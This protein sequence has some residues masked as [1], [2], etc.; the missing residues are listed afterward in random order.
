MLSSRRGVCGSRKTRGSSVLSILSATRSLTLVGLCLGATGTAFA[1]GVGLR[2]ES[3][4]RGVAVVE[5]R[6][7]SLEREYSHRRGLIGAH[8]ADVRFENAVYDFLVGDYSNAC[9]SFYTLVESE[10]LVDAAMA[11]DAEWYLAECLMEDGNRVTAVEAYQRVIDF[12]QAHPF[13][14]DAVRRQLEA[15]GFLKDSDG[16]YGVYNRYIVTSV[17]PTTDEVRY[18]M[19][20]SFYHQGD[21]TRAKS[22][23]A[24]V[25]GDSN[26][27]TRA[28]YFMGA[29]LVAEGQYESAIPQFERVTQHVPPMKADGYYGVGGIQEFAARRALESEVVELA[30]LALGRINYELGKYAEAQKHYRSVTTESD[31][32]AD[33]LY[34]LVWVYLK[35]DQWLD[36]I[37]QIEIFLI[38]FPEHQY[39]FQLRL[40]LG[41]LHMRRGAYERA[42][43]SYEEVVD[44]YGPIQMRLTEIK[45]SP[46][47]PDDFFGA[48]VDAEQPEAV[49][50]EIP[51]FAISLL[52]EDDHVGRAVDIRR[53]LDRQD[54]DL[55][56]SRSLIEQIAPVLQGGSQG[57]GTF[58]AGRTQ[59]GGVQNDSLKIRIDVIDADLA[60][61]EDQGSAAQAGEVRRLR[62]EFNTLMGRYSQIRSDENDATAREGAYAGQVDAVQTSAAQGGQLAGQQMAE[63]Q[64]LKQRLVENASQLSGQEVSEI[65]RRIAAL[66]AG[67]KDDMG[68]LAQAASPATKRRVMNTVGGP[69]NAVAQRR[70]LADDLGALRDDI[71]PL[72]RTVRDTSGDFRRLDQA[73]D[74]ALKVERRALSVM[75][76]L[77]RAEATELRQMRAKLSEHMDAVIAL[78]SE[79][80]QVSGSATVVSSGVTRVGIGRVEG[81]FT[82]TVMGAD[83]GIVDVYWTRKAQVSD[84]IERLGEERGLRSRELDDR[85]QMIRQRMGQGGGA[86]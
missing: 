64:A 75:G 70:L 57:I 28:R 84:E 13:F 17:V 14:N 24:E 48:L 2:L 58:Y 78:N 40:L 82:E 30:R 22:L 77:E 16:F 29:I 71:V 12:G 49:D 43:V 55:E 45:L 1:S 79:F 11:R 15:Y 8:A 37:N 61:L 32:F 85:F 33:Q 26:M 74:R 59:I 73:W 31:Q 69:S 5:S 38:A 54:D 52:A 25:S 35:Q 65:H 72:R 23:F 9:T 46:S 76:K 42:L 7:A 81:E 53:E 51:A 10:A 34:E 68:G 80:G 18:S 36:A 47:K 60:I 66:E 50:P 67:L 62:Q 83:R 21:W 6:L 56:V 4:D 86:Q 20:K 63:I 19:G 3:V 39:A 41:H 44:K 27:F